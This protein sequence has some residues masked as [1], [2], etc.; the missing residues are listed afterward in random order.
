MK[1]MQ[2]STD[3]SHEETSKHENFRPLPTLPLNFSYWEQNDK[4][5]HI[6]AIERCPSLLPNCIY[7]FGEDYKDEYSGPDVAVEQWRWFENAL[8]QSKGADYV[9]VVGHRPVI[10][11]CLRDRKPCELRVS[12]RWVSGWCMIDVSISIEIRSRRAI[13]QRRPVKILEQSRTIPIFTRLIV[14]VTWI[15]CL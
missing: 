14:H 4:T 15:F 2:A 6:F 8:E 3:S 12:D 5:Y 7:R 11:G 13:K 10:S 1:T 9:V